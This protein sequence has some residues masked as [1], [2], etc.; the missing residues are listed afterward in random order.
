MHRCRALTSLAFLGAAE[1]PDEDKWTLKTSCHR[2]ESGYRCRCTQVPWREIV[3][4]SGDAE[5]A[6]KQRFKFNDQHLFTVQ[7]H[8]KG[9]PKVLFKDG[10]PTP[11]SDT[12]RH[13]PRL[14]LKRAVQEKHRRSVGV[15]FLRPSD[16]VQNR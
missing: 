16:A 5:E 2:R 4:D 11:I 3:V 15:R 12:S 14:H 10:R 8:L 6:T 9:P 7:R 1:L 13:E